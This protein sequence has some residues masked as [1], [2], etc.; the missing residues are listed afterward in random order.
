M[1][2]TR[3]IELLNTAWIKGSMSAANLNQSQVNTASERIIM[4]YSL[5]S[6]TAGL[7]FDF[8][9]KSSAIVSSSQV[10]LDKT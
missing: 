2:L 7:L 3:E 4:P 9:S 10:V 6:A 8:D 5:E 1:E